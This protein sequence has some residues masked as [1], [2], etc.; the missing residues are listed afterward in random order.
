MGTNPNYL[1]ATPAWRIELKKRLLNT[2]TVWGAID[3]TICLVVFTVA[4]IDSYKTYKTVKSFDWK[5]PE[6]EIPEIRI[7]RPDA[8]GKAFT[9]EVW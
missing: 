1:L 6:I 5:L 2:L 7:P 8:L 4:A 9:S 3:A